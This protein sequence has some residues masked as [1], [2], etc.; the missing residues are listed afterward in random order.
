MKQTSEIT[1]CT[2]TDGRFIIEFWLGGYSNSVEFETLHA[3]KTLVEDSVNLRVPREFRVL[4][5]DTVGQ[6][7]ADHCELVSIE[8]Y[9]NTP[10]AAHLYEADIHA[11]RHGIA[12][13]ITELRTN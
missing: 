9:E 6:L 13:P 12:Q 11:L 8:V 1:V 3:T 5:A 10:D 7:L 2:T 4:I